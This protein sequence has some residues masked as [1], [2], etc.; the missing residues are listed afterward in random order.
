LPS[1]EAGINFANSI[2]PGLGLAESFK[3]WAGANGAKNSD[4]WGLE[5]SQLPKNDPMRAG[6]GKVESNRGSAAMN[7]GIPVF[8]VEGRID[9][10][11]LEKELDN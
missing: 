1:N 11:K 10:K 2:S 5:Y 8:R 3:K 7:D 6:G 9:S 4:D